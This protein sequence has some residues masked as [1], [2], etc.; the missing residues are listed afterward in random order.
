VFPD[1]DRDFTRRNLCHSNPHKR[2]QPDLGVIG[3]NKDDR[4]RG[5]DR[6]VLLAIIL[7]RSRRPSILLKVL[8]KRLAVVCARDDI[9]LDDLSGYGRVPS[10]VGECAEESL[11]DCPADELICVFILRKHVDAA[12]RLTFDPEFVAA[13]DVVGD[14]VDHA[15]AAVGDDV[16][17]LGLG[18]GSNTFVKAEESSELR[19]GQFSYLVGPDALT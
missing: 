9:R 6:E 1:L 11:V 8:V 13:V 10:V 7:P 15:F 3:L 2:H 4:T 18:D 14:L 17:V 12:V 16:V 5:N 19:G